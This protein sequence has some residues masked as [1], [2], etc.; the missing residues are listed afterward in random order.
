MKEIMRQILSALKVSH[1]ARFMHRDVKPE[2]IMVETSEKNPEEF[3]LKLVDWGS[4]RKMDIYS[5]QNFTAEVVPLG[6]QASRVAFQHEKV[7]GNCGYLVCGV[8]FR[9]TAVWRKTD[10]GAEC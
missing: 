2:N 4:S 6:Y 10:S 1:T 9:G 3:V 8:Y 5:D 7:L